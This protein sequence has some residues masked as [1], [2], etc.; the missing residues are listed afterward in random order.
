ML[1]ERLNIN[2]YFFYNIL[3][4]LLVYFLTFILFKEYYYLAFTISMVFLDI[5]IIKKFNFILYLTI[6][7]FLLILFIFD[8]SSIL[9]TLRFILILPVLIFLPKKKKLLKFFISCLL[10]TIT[11]FLL[12][13]NWASFYRN[14][15]NNESLVVNELKSLKLDNLNYFNPE[16]GTYVLDLWYTKCAACYKNMEDLKNWA[17]LNSKYK[18]KII[19]VNILLDG[20]SFDENKKIVEKYDFISTFSNL[21]FE[22]FK[23]LGVRTYPTQ[24]VVRNNKIIFV[25]DLEVDKNVILNNINEYL[26]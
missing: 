5:F 11:H 22:E 23:K 20:E 2:K 17:K 25:G 9:R 21:N 10:I 12:Q 4:V 24:I 16:N 15:I 14:Q 26:N 13:P 18:N 3:L 1:V 7:F 19:L 6:P 8:F